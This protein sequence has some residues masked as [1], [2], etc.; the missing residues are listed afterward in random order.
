MQDG[1]WLAWYVYA[2]GTGDHPVRIQFL[3]MMGAGGY[4]IRLQNGLCIIVNKKF[5]DRLTPIQDPQWPIVD[6][7]QLR[8]DPECTG[9]HEVED[10]SGK[11]L[12]RAASSAL[13]ALAYEQ[14][15]ALYSE[16]WRE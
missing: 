6:A 5:M 10:S 15:K 2:E 3:T 16:R 12:A 7:S 1:Q 4:Q 14:N 9:G 11:E 13:A 8:R